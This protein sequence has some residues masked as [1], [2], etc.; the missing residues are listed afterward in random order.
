M[1][2]ERI[3]VDT[4]IVEPDPQMRDTLRSIA[5][6]HR[7]GLLT[8]HRDDFLHRIDGAKRV[9]DMPERDELRFGG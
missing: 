2:A 5:D 6:D 3:E 4:Q 1:A 9:G 8:N 7:V